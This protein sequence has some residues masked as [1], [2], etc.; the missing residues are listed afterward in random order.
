MRKSTITKTWIAGVILMAAGLLVG[1]VSLGLMLA[2]GGQFT[3]APGE[4]GYDFVPRLDGFFWT[5]VS[6]MIAGFA[7]AAIGGIVQ[8]TA[9]IGAL[10]NTYQLADRTWFVVLLAGGLLGLAFGIVGFAAMVAYVIAGPDSTVTGEAR[11]PTLA[12]PPAMLAPTS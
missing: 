12:Q 2:Y 5:M 9:W 1:G 7:V 8:L 3:P 4:N 11:L 10:V 6:L